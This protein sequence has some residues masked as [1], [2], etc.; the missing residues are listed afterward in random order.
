MKKKLMYIALMTLTAAF[1]LSGCSLFATSD[2]KEG[3]NSGSSGTVKMT[4]NYS[5]EDPANLDFDTRYVLYCDEN[6]LVISQIPAEYGILASYSII[7]AKDDA[8]V[9]DYEFFVC[10]SAEHAAATA[11]L[12]ASQGQTLL[13]AEGD[14]TVL[15]SFSDGDTMEATLVSIQSF[16]MISEAT[17][18]AYVTFMQSSTGGTLME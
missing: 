13:E 3:G 12:Y 9:A 15:Y 8:P 5:F 2:G 17:V 14:A 4:G 7:Y 10:D 16:G 6:S 11:D 18:S 1:L